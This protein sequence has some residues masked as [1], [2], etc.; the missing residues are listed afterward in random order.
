MATKAI[1]ALSTSYP[2]LQPG[3]WFAIDRAGVTGKTTYAQL[4][5]ELAGETFATLTVTS[6][7]IN[8]GT[9]DGA[10][11]GGATPAAGTFTT[12]SG[13][14]AALTT[15]SATVLDLFATNTANTH[16][17][18][19]LARTTTSLAFQT[20]TSASAVVTSDY[21]M[22]VGASGVTSHVFS[23]T[24]VDRLSVTSTGA[25]VTGSISATSSVS[26]AGGSTSRFGNLHAQNANSILGRPHTDATDGALNGFRWQDIYLQNSPN[27]SSDARLKEDIRDLSGAEQRAAA[28]IK[29]RTFIM[30]DT[31]QRK[32]GYIAQEVIDAMRSEGLDAF[33]YGLVTDGELYGV[34]M[35]AINAFRLG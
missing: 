30:R 22:T 31:G 6:A 14:T 7:D 15:A 13:A 34:D 11:I 5:T 27:V 28:K 26:A 33:A 29:A 24:G 12:I 4:I 35:D 10:V 25:T 9:I 19:R 3:D 23:V 8:G 16:E 21:V 32:I 20:L 18:S 17:G 1:S 2:T